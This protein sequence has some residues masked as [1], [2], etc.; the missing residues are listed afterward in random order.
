HY[1]SAMGTDE[2]VYLTEAPRDGRMD[3]FAAEGHWYG[4]PWGHL[5]VSGG[6]WNFDNALSVHDGL[7]WGTK[8]TKGAS[9]MIREYIGPAGFGNGKV[10]A[11]SAEYN[12]SLARIA[13]HPRP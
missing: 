10:A 1:A 4:V 6:L 7:W 12:T 2:R 8:W 13:W 5:G 3:V 11:I 9:D